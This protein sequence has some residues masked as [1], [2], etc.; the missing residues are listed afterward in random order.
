MTSIVCSTTV[1]L[2]AVS[3][4]GL[5][6][7]DAVVSYH[8]DPAGRRSALAYGSRSTSRGGDTPQP[9]RTPRAGTLLRDDAAKTYELTAEA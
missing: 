7:D 3:S 2:L 4:T 9:A 1:L 5:R 6:E 8:P